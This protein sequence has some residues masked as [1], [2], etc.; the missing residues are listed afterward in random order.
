MKDARRTS[1]RAGFDRETLKDAQLMHVHVSQLSQD[2]SFRDSQ[3]S[4]ISTTWGVVSTTGT[5]HEEHIPEVEIPHFCY[6]LY[7][8][9][10]S[11]CITRSMFVHAKATA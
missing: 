8:W 5:Y 6:L 3:P 2:K 4:V 7:R 10:N 11:R 9:P 1:C